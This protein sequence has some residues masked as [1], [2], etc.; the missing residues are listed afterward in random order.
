V[1]SLNGFSEIIKFEFFSEFFHKIQRI[2]SKPE[3]SVV[4][5]GGFSL[6]IIQNSEINSEIFF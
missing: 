5:H 4:Y 3:N 1:Y 6:N 2:Q